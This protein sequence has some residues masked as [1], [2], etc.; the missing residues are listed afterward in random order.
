M[1]GHIKVLFSFAAMFKNSLYILVLVGILIVTGCSKFNKVVKNGTPEEKYNA[2]N[3]YYSKSDYFH[4]LQL[5]EELI[6]LYRGNAKIKDLYYKYAY[7][8]YY[9]KDLELASYHFKYYAKTF[10]RDSLAQEALYMSAYCKYLLSPK[11]ELDQSATKTAISE[12]QSF[13]NTYPESSR[14]ADANKNIDE[15]RAKLVEKD[16]NIAKL[17]YQ[18]EYYLSA[19]SALKQHIKDYPSTPYQEECLYLIIKANNDYARKSVISKQYERYS[20]AI[21]AYNDYMVKFPEG[22]HAKDAMRI[23]RNAQS[24]LKDLKT[25]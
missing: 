24:K 13:I 14:V 5:Y 12:F 4:A 1:L 16:F 21:A 6:V 18:T 23:M 15:L 11:F 9:E 17:Y 25:T 20:N 19:I 10:P 8:H 7:S 2:A 22:K 3:E